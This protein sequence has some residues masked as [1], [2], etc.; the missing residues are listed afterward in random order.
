[1]GGRVSV[2][3]G[4]LHIFRTKLIWRG[5]CYERIHVRNFAQ[6]TVEVD[7]G[8]EYESDYAD[9]FEVRGQRRAARGQVLP[10]RIG[11]GFVELGYEGLDAVTRRTHIE[12]RPDPQKVTAQSMRMR[13]RLEPQQE[14]LFSLTISCSN[15]QA[16]VRAASYDAARCQA[17]HAVASGEHFAC[18]I[19]T[20][21]EH[22][23]AWV[24]RSA[25]DLNMLLTNTSH[26]LYP[27]AGVPWFD[28]PIGRHGIITALESLWL[29]PQVARGVLSFL[30]ATQATEPDPE[31]DADPGKI[32]HEARSG[33]MAALEEVPF[34]RYYGSV[35][36]TPLFVVLAG[37]YFQR[38]GD[39]A[40][41]ESIW[42]NVS[43]ALEWM[44]RYG[45]ADHDGFIEYARH[46]PNGLVH[47]GWKDSNDS[48]FH[49]DGRLAEGPIALCEVQGYA[50]AARMA[51]ADLADAMDDKVL[52]RA[53]RE[54]ARELQERFQQA[55]WCEDLGVY[56]LALD[57]EKKPCR[58]RSSNTGHCVYS[59]IA[60]PEHA[61]SILA[62]LEDSS[63][64]SGWGVRTLAE[65]ES[66]FNPMGYH[67][68]SIWPHDNAIIAA[69]QTNLS[70]KSLAMRILAAHLEA[71][72]FF[73]SS[74]L[75][76]LFCGFRRRGG[77]APTGYPVA[78]S[79]QAWAAGAVF[80][81]L[82][83]CL[84]ISVDA[85]HFRVVLRAPALPS[86]I[87]RV[88]IR[89]LSTPAGSV[90]LTVHRHLGTLSAN[91]E[92]RSGRLDVVVLD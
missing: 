55:F 39:L 53:L 24:R 9:I 65:T 50:Y 7:L 84:G 33:E 88:S 60:S 68:G 85:I 3:R 91:V 15:A 2:P 1:M 51:G 82:Q 5:V 41:I 63:F 43:A 26:G 83:A 56:A 23:N 75:P 30:A 86:G 13:V 87:D 80:M 77:K 52:A 59:G 32:L 66:R 57:G 64:F 6:Q 72:T 35:D 37:A 44:D 71:S 45:D 48:V 73:D 29:A 8:L 25:A 92:R 49:A 89:G 11:D 27:Y 42:R 38:T 58:V 54:S 18:T 61:S 17:E 46:S 74:R 16:A 70:S 31:R 81:M 36:A 76:E 79:P 69:G 14:Q 10:T 62:T 22:L 40:F 34:G 47:Q 20:S 19:E 28:T 4:S 90:D 78:C 21:H 12:C 67:N